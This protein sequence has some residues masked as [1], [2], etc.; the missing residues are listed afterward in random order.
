[1]TPG[2]QAGLDVQRQLKR[3]RRLARHVWAHFKED[4]CLEEAASL[5]YTSLLAM[6]PLL[7]VVFGI[8]SAFP[9]FDKW[10]NNLQDFI[11]SNFLPESGEQIV[12][13]INTFLDSV[14][15]LTLP[16]T[17]VL[18]ATALLLMVRIEVAFNRIRRVDR[19]LRYFFHAIE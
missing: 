2:G 12:P 4:R 1:M 3:G 11:F 10:S 15:G 13:Y 19:S 17:V 9:V 8:V 7:A 6:V 14:S 18:I 5:G 16:G